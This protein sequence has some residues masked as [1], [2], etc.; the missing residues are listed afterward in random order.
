[1]TDGDVQ[2]LVL[3]KAVVQWLREILFILHKSVLW[4]H[5]LTWPWN[6]IMLDLISLKL[7]YLSTATSEVWRHLAV[8]VLAES[9]V[10]A[11]DAVAPVVAQQ[12]VRH[13]LLLVG[14][15]VGRRRKW[16]S[17]SGTEGWVTGKTCAL[18]IA[19]K[20]AM[21]EVAIWAGNLGKYSKNHYELDI[22]LIKKTAHGSKRK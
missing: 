12:V 22:F 15:R 17:I 6:K 11:V 7:F 14:A 16:R 5:D 19:C 9:L 1:M 3:L 13:A 4:Y 8:R 10:T 20:E 18:R 21:G 2:R